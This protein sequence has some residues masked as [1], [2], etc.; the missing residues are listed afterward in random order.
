MSVGKLETDRNTHR[1]LGGVELSVLCVCVWLCQHEGLPVLR[2]CAETSSRTPTDIKA[3]PKHSTCQPPSSAPYAAKHQCK[4]PNARRPGSYS[5]CLCSHHTCLQRQRHS[6][7][8]WNL[9]KAWCSKTNVERVGG[10]MLEI[11]R[12]GVKVVC[13]CVCVYPWGD[14]ERREVHLGWSP[15]QSPRSHS[16]C[17]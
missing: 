13:V 5:P 3:V 16:P 4:N 2:A 6:A 11:E 9:W 1:R 12:K 14:Q 7:A 17:I 15:T 8:Q 10:E